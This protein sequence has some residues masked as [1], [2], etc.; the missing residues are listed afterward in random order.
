MRVWRRVRGFEPARLLHLL[1]FRTSAF[2][3]SANPP[4]WS[5]TRESNSHWSWLEARCHTF[6]R[7]AHMEHVE[8]ADPSTS[9]LATRR[10][11]AELYVHGEE[12]FTFQ[13]LP[14]LGHILFI[15]FQWRHLLRWVSFAPTILLVYEVGF[16]PTTF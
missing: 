4:Y 2:D 9:S 8:G 5:A 7:V 1:V 12:V 6:R 14:L 11:T 10:S 16:E 13:L 15:S 3:R